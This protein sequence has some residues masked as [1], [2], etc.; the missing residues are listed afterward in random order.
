MQCAQSLASYCSGGAPGGGGAGGGGAGGGGAG[1]GGSGGGGNCV[2]GPGGSTARFVFD[3]LI[4]PMQHS[5]Y[6]Y[7]LVGSGMARNQ[8]GIVMG[9]LA[10]QNLNNRRPPTW[11]C[12]R[13]RRSCC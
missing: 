8:L 11:R 9:A 2:P 7:D 10:Q 4:L 1:G 12:S 5:D 3:T 6:A 13:A